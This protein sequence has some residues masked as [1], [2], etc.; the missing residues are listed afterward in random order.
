M[1]IGMRFCFIRSSDFFLKENRNIKKTKTTFYVHLHNV[2]L[3][4]LF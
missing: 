2:D 1:S 4:S 3:E